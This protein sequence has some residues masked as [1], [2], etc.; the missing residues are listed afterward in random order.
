MN[1]VLITGASGYIGKAISSDVRAKSFHFLSR[2]H[3]EKKNWHYVKDFS[4]VQGA[5]FENSLQNINVVVHL[6]AVAHVYDV[7]ESHLY[8]INYRATL[9]LAKQASLLGVKRFV[10]LSTINV[11]GNSSV[12]N[13]KTIPKPSDYS[14]NLR[15]IVENELLELGKDTGMEIVIIRSPL[16]YGKNAPGNFGTLL[17][18][19]KKSLPLPLGGINNQR[20]FVSTYNLVDLIITCI[21]HPNAENQTFLVSDDEDIST[22]NLLRKLTLAADKKPWLIPVPVSFLKLLASLVG[23]KASVESFSS[24]LAVDIFHTKKTLNWT[25]PITLDEGIRRCF[26]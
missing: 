9:D 15:L 18:V 7:S 5:D 17:K 11:Y 13:Y 14:S 20:S 2:K 19:A 10:Y 4:Q 26:K 1:E 24:S 22:S 21:D 6:A 3:I 23:K 8:N 16:V 25:P 12:I